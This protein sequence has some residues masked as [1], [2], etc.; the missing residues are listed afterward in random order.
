MA[1]PGEET[2]TGPND[3][4][5]LSFGVPRHNALSFI[6]ANS[7]VYLARL[8]TRSFVPVHAGREL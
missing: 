2:S 5:S 1:Q 8:V 6:E 3:V 4:R 7:E